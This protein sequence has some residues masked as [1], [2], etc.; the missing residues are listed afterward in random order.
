MGIADR[1]LAIAIGS[2]PKR[3]PIALTPANC[4]FSFSSRRLAPLISFGN[5]HAGSLA[6]RVV[7][8]ER[9]MVVFLPPAS[10]RV[11]GSPD[12]DTLVGPHAEKLIR[13]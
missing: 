6:H 10:H 5:G 13:S 4:D 9:G 7:R 11:R 8:T 3:Q 12:N 1:I 2:G